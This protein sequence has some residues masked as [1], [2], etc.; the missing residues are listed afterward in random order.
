MEIE[1]EEITTSSIKSKSPWEN[2]EYDDWR[3][4]IFDDVLEDIDNYL[5][6]ETYVKADLTDRV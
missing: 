6:F 3:N 2:D 5:G 4:H 1:I